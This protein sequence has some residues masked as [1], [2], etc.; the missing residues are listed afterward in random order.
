MLKYIHPESLKW[1]GVE[2]PTSAR[3][4]VVLGLYYNVLAPQEND[5][6]VRRK[7]YIWLQAKDPTVPFPLTDDELFL[8][9]PNICKTIAYKAFYGQL[10]E[11]IQKRLLHSSSFEEAL[12]EA[13]QHIENNYTVLYLQYA[14]FFKL[15]EKK[16]TH[17][18]LKARLQRLRESLEICG[19]T[20]RKALK[21]AI[22]K[23]RT[24]QDDTTQLRTLLR[25]SIEKAR[26]QRLAKEDYW[27]QRIVPLVAMIK[28]TLA[29]FP[30]APYFLALQEVTPYSL[31][32]LK[33][34]FATNVKWISYNN[35]SGLPTRFLNP[36][37]ETVFG[38]AGALTATIALSPDLH[39]VRHLLGELPSC[40]GNRCTMLGVEVENLKTGGNFAIFS[41]H[42]DY[43]VEDNLYAETTKAISCFIQKFIGTRTLPFIFGGDF[44]AFEGM[45]GE[46][47]LAGIQHQEPLDR[48]HD[49]RKG[50][51]YCPP[52]ILDATFLGHARDD[53]KMAVDIEG[54]VQPNALDHIFLTPP[55]V[56][57]FRKAGVYDDL[58]KIVDPVEQPD[59]FLKHLKARHTTS[60][61][62]LN[63]VLFISP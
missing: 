9:S 44:N 57:G 13:L 11:E 35:V 56:F 37:Q 19:K 18:S 4:D 40:S 60:D 59:L 1:C 20:P 43:V 7:F 54:K 36:E 6:E 16:E 51:F 58:G 42:A 53:Y 45:G 33:E 5:S 50:P 49:F 62:F 32:R 27:Q 29:A 34:S 52:A 2:P 48:A 47:Y 63:G 24:V 15:K 46:D 17:P 26:G 14:H 8:L 21:Y 31:Q 39:P 23:Y 3:D 41:I 25:G 28:F 30:N 10:A 55:T 61:H 22:K 38:E 12:E